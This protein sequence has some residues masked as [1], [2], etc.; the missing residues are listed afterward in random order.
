MPRLPGTES[1]TGPSLMVEITTEDP[2]AEPLV[3]FRGAALRRATLISWLVLLL[4]AAQGIRHEIQPT[5][6]LG[7]IA[8]AFVA[9]LAVSSVVD[10]QKV[11][12]S[13]VGSWA[14]WV[15]CIFLTLSLGALASLP[16]LFDT[17]MPMFAGVVVLT[18]LVLERV[19]HVFVSVLAVFLLGL[20]AFRTGNAGDLES[21][22]IP[23]LT[24][25]VVAS[26][27][28]FLGTEFGREARRSAE[29]LRELQAQREDFER[30]YAVSKTISGV[31]SLE[32]GLPEIVGRICRFV[33]AQVGVV[34]LH[35]EHRHMLSVVSPMWVNG[36]PLEVPRLDTPI[37]GS[38]ALARAFRSGKPIP[39]RDV[40]RG[41]DRAG[42]LTYLGIEEAI[43]APLRVERENVGVIVV[44]DPADGVFDDLHVESVSSLA[45]AAAL[46]LSQLGRYEQAAEL[47]RRMSEIAQM[48]TDFVSVVS[49]ELRSPLTSIIGS[50]DTIARPGISTDASAEL[51]ESAR[52]QAGRLQ[53]LIED[54]LM[55]SRIDRHAVPIS[56]ENIELGPFLRETARTVTTIETPTL[57]LDGFVVRG[58]P[59]HLGRVFI[60]LLENAGKYAPGS[61]VEIVAE[62]TDGGRIAISVVDHGDGIPAEARDRIFERFTQLEHADTRT[63]GGTGLGLSVVRGLVEAMDG[64]VSVSETPGG[65]ATFM[66]ELP[67][68]RGALVSRSA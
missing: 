2:R 26:A 61:P 24:V 4:V 66:V 7:V 46:V 62:Q 13:R 52:R 65:G 64:A 56:P 55:V 60:N 14:A 47:S 68:G 49:H 51:L 57:E 6:T 22:A 45:G 17:A 44:A 5:R 54:L 19:R 18:G 53:R 42:V 31:Q 63:R 25:G 23:A 11:L 58:D 20:A 15:F 34:F 1:S 9:G 32:E 16:E 40:G 35:E 50:L 41:R 12:A 10:W 21:L 39:L 28:A 8:L 29:R 37:S 3:R 36:N 38:S 33:G 30:L 59:D 67:A 48:K 43:V 27:T